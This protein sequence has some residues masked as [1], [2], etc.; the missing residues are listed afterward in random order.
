MRSAENNPKVAIFLFEELFRPSDISTVNRLVN[1]AADHTSYRYPVTVPRE[2][3]SRV[4]NASTGHAPEWLNW[5]PD[6]ARVVDRL[7]GDLMRLVGYGEE[8]EWKI[9]LQN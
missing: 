1:F 8:P 7:C 2:F 3:T 4:Q 5:S 6:Q 9:K